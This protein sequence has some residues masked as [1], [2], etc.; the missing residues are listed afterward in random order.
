MKQPP[1]NDLR[2]LSPDC[3][4]MYLALLVQFPSLLHTRMTPAVT[5]TGDI[6]KYGKILYIKNNLMFLSKSIF[7]YIL[8][9]F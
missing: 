8:N 1:W 4:G 6:G 9:Q 3:C 2:L 7:F 5:Q